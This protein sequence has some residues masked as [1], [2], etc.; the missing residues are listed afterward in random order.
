MSRRKNYAIISNED[1]NDVNS[2]AGE[3][4]KGSFSERRIKLMRQDTVCYNINFLLGIEA[5]PSLQNI[6]IILFLI[7]NAVYEIYSIYNIVLK[8]CWFM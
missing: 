5:G 4:C 6:T 3:L 7:I 1:R 2:D 8:T